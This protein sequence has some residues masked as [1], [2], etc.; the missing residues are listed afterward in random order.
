MKAIITTKPGP[1]DVLHLK[2]I[3]KPEPKRN[4][5]LIKIHATTVTAGDVILRSLPGLVWIPMQLFFGLKRKRVLGHEFAG[6]IEAIGSGVDQFREGDKVFGT[7]TE[8]SIGSYAEYLS[9]P[10]SAVLATKPVNVTYEE[11]AAIPIGGLAALHFLNEAG[12]QG[13]QRVL[14]R[15]C[16]VSG[17]VVN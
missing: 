13:E 9:M 8:L 3:E 10:E 1:P 14:G 2:E 12:I 15:V 5:V 11:A 6:E 7:T 16:K 4:E 17:L